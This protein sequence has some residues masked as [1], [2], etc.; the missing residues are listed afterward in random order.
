MI[1]LFFVTEA[2]LEE[3]KMSIGVLMTGEQRINK[4]EGLKDGLVDLGYDLHSFE[5][6]VEEAGDDSSR[7]EISAKNLIQNNVDVIASFGGIE[8]QVLK[9]VM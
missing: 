2:S 6:I 9:Q 4:L 7:L 3:E 5:F 1:T 8:I